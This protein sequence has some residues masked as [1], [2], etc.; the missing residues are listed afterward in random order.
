M[1]KPGYFVLFDE[2]TNVLPSKSI[3]VLSHPN[4]NTA[5]TVTDLE[6]YT[7]PI[8]PLNRSS[9]NTQ[10]SVFLAT[11]PDSVQIGDAPKATYNE[12]FVSKIFAFELYSKCR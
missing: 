8:K 4:S 3:N 6:E 1:S 11:K 2:L 7:W 12:S 10:V 5:Q 9:N